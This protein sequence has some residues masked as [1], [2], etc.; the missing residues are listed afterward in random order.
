M[1]VRPTQDL[2]L[3]RPDTDMPVLRGTAVTM[4]RKEGYLW[5]T[6]YVPRIRTY[7]GFETPKPLLVEMNRGDGDLMTI[8]RDVLALTKINYNACDYARNAE[9]CRSRRR[10]PDGIAARL[11]S[12][13]HAVPLLHLANRIWARPSDRAVVNRAHW[14]PRLCPRLERGESKSTTSVGRAARLCD[15]GKK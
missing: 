14:I 7:P 13:A 8:M 6:G 9:I 2:R 15:V 4:S 12:A 10:N 5:T 11:G 1:I 3:F